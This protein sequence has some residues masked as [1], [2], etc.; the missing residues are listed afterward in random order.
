MGTVSLRGG[1]G[2]PAPRCAAGGG[3]AK[4]VWVAGGGWRALKQPR[5]AAVGGGGQGGAGRRAGGG[6]GSV[7]ALGGGGL[8][9]G[10]WGRGPGELPRRKCEAFLLFFFLLRVFQYLLWCD[11]S[12]A[13]LI[14]PG[15]RAARCGKPCAFVTSGGSRGP[16]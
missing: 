3:A 2:L 8:E 10:R 7:T 13:L 15:G 5:P 16:A 11:L 14:G 9:E 12:Q 1:A 4:R 6:C